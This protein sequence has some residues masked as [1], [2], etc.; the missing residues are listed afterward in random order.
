[1]SLWLSLF[2]QW[3][4]NYFRRMWIIQELAMN[5]NMSLFMCGN[6]QFAR[7]ALHNASA[8]CQNFSE[9]LPQALADTASPNTSFF[10][11]NF[12]DLWSTAYNV[13]RLISL[14]ASN[15]DLETVLDL[16]RKSKVKDPRDKIYGLLGLL[17]KPIAALTEPNYSRTK[18]EVYVDFATAMLRHCSRLDALLSWCESKD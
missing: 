14:K 2:R 1:M 18:E 7:Q 13:H 8:F 10:G 6:R 9:T 15:T 5:S 12:P 17:P 16:A 4:R 3:S 11:I